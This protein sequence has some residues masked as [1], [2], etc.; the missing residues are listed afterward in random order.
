MLASV[1]PWSPKS[2]RLLGSS[3]PSLA[4]I[5]ATPSFRASKIIWVASNRFSYCCVL[6]SILTNCFSRSSRI[7]LRCTCSTLPLPWY[8]AISALSS[9]AC[10]SSF[11]CSLL[12]SLTKLKSEKF[13]SSAAMNAVTRSSMSVM[14]VAFLICLKASSYSASCDAPFFASVAQSP[15]AV[16][17]PAVSFPSASAKP[18]SA[19]LSLLRMSASFIF[20]SCSMMRPSS[21]HSASNCAASLSPCARRAAIS[22]CAWSR[23][24]YAMLVISTTLAISRFFSASSLF[25]FL[26]TSSNVI[27]SRRNTSISSRSFLLWEMASLKFISVLSSLFSRTLTCFMSSWSFSFAAPTPPIAFFCWMMAASESARCWSSSSTRRLSM[28]IFRM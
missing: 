8:R 10:S 4:Y 15:L 23:A 27:R 20:L 28:S 2:S 16:F 25:A 13:W 24:S 19:A 11:S 6:A 18:S 9:A 7:R 3:Q 21:R 1:T 17:M 26:Y 5:D 12:S 14:P 22:L